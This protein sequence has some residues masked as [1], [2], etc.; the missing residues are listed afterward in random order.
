MKVEKFATGIL[1]TNTY[2]VINEETKA[3]V[4]VDPAALPKRLK[5]YI[6]EN[7]LTIEAVLLTHAHFD[8][9][10]GVDLFEEEYGVSAVYVHEN[11]AA[12]MENPMLNLSNVYT[13]G[14]TYSKYTCIRDKQVLKHAGMEF[15]V[16]HTPGHTSGGV[17]YYVAE[18]KVLFSGDTLFQTSIGRTDFETSSMS[19]MIH[20][21]K[22]KLFELPDDT[23]V[24]P[25]H[26]GETKIG[27]EKTHNPYVV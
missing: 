11:D 9:I 7:E 14:Y 16:I 12:M 1:G 4:V 26:M 5:N 6:E 10:M 20:S 25:G 13:R 27:Y 19:D 24:C 22:D 18:G 17:S 2:L 23:L 8:H 3:A 21:I 15:Q